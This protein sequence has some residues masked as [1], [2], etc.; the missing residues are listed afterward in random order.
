MAQIIVYSQMARDKYMYQHCIKC[1]ILTRMAW[2]HYMLKLYIYHQ[3]S[4]WTLVGL[5]EKRVR[6]R[7]RP[8]GGRGCVGRRRPP[9]GSKGNFHHFLW[10][11]RTKMTAENSGF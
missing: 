1:L 4:K 6:S 9:L 2:L 5:A 3:G 10:S 8:R 11:L 7:Q